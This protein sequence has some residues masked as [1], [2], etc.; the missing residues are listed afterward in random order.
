MTIQSAATEQ[1]TH[2]HMLAAPIANGLELLIAALLATFWRLVACIR[3]PAPTWQ[4]AAELRS[5]S[6]SQSAT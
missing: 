5:A 2:A 3:A 1:Q 4:E 6:Q